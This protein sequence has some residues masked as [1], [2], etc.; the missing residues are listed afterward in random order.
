M[1]TSS[2]ERHAGNPRV[3]SG[4]SGVLLGVLEELVVDAG[5]RTRTATKSK[6]KG[7]YLAWMP[8]EKALAIVRKAKGTPGVLGETTKRIHKLFHNVAPSESA[9]Y[10]WP[11]RTGSERRVGLIRSLTYVVPANIKSPE[12]QGYRWVHKFGDHGELGHGPL[13]SRGEKVYSD[14]LKPMLLENGRG[15]LFIQRRPGNKYDVTKW[16]YW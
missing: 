16:I 11:E 12:K 2:E 5:N 3:R 8:S 10:E 6:L 14:S 1:T 4:R 15:Q 13:D 9:T 7:M